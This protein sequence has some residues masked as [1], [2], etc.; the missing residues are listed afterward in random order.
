MRT[1]ASMT[2]WNHLYYV[3]HRAHHGEEL[4]QDLLGKFL[5]SDGHL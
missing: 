5:L 4:H 2:D 1:G 3:L